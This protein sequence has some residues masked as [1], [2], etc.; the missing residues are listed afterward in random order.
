M[1]LMDFS[2]NYTLYRNTQTIP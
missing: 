1:K 2:A